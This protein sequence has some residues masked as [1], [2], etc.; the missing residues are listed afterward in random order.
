MLNTSG[1]AKIAVHRIGG[2]FL[3]G[4]SV[5]LQVLAGRADTNTANDHVGWSMAKT[6][7]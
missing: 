1:V 5:Y 3:L 4:I 7:G 2:I 6:A